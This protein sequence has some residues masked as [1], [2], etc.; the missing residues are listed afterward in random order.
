LESA[1]S[2]EG[3]LV[4]TS[5]TPPSEPS[6]DLAVI[7]ATA[8]WEAAARDLRGATRPGGRA[9]VVAGEPPGG[10]LAKLTGGSAQPVPTESIVA[11]LTRLGWERVRPIGEREGTRFVE[12]FAP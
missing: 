5:A 7:E 12:G 1:A 6:F 8:G 9:I 4:E 11:T 3:V 2:R 10:L